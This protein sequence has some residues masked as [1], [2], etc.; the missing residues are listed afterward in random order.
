MTTAKNIEN[1]QQLKKG[2]GQIQT[3]VASSTFVKVTLEIRSEP[4]NVIS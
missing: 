4:L 3:L 1:L 2:V